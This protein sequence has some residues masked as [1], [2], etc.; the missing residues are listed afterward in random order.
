MFRSKALSY[1]I[2]A[3]TEV[4]K[5]GDGAGV[6]AA[7]VAKEYDLPSAY[8]AKIMSQLAK[9]NVLQSDRGPNGGFKLTRAANKITLLEIYEAVHDTLGKDAASALP[10]AL[11][12]PVNAAIDATCGV[13]RKR[14]EGVSLG[15]L[16]K[17]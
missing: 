5:Q 9:A 16:M 14:L 2:L 1:A 11:A 12:K 15:D 13:I 3:A 4:A 8:G 7:A 6:Q 17:K 10:P